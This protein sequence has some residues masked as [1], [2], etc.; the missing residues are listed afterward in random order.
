MPVIPLSDADF[1]NL[2]KISEPFVDPT[3]ESR[4][5]RLIRDEMTRLGFAGNGNG[6]GRMNGR[7]RLTQEAIRRLSVDSHESLTFTKLLSATVD[8]REMHRPKWHSFMNH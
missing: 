6:Q 2:K 5:S 3:P 8:S 7:V 4:I 1:D